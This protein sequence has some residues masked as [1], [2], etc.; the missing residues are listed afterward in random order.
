MRIVAGA[1]K[2]RRP[3]TLK[4]RHVRPTTDAAKEAL[5][6]ILRGQVPRARVL[7]LFAGSGSR[8]IEALSRG[9]AHVTFVD[10]SAASLRTVRANLADLG[11]PRE[12]S[13]MIRLDAR[14]ALSQMLT[15]PDPFDLIFIDPPYD[16]T[17]AHEALQAVGIGGERLVT[18]EGTV[19]VE[20][21][22]TASLAEFYGMLTRVRVEQYGNSSI[23]LYRRVVSRDADGEA[24]TPSG[25]GPSRTDS[26]GSLTSR[27]RGE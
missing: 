1:Y 17:L 4:G 18:A 25:H 8:G 20:H 24:R 5:F 6:A 22:P 7:D 16:S 11:V 9:A 21:P 3:P 14:T 23:S 27:S 2:S 15:A 12:Q 13:N 19:V 26:A 10:S